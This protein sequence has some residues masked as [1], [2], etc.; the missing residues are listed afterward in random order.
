[1]AHHSN[2]KSFLDVKFPHELAELFF[3]KTE[4]I[5]KHEMGCE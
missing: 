4:M 1:M 2:T 5:L 3:P